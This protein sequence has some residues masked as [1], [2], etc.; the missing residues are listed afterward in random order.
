MTQLPLILDIVFALIAVIFIVV[1]VRR[2]FIKSLIQSA[3]FLLAIVVTYF[4]GPLVSGFIKDK[5][6][7]QPIHDWLTEAGTNVV[8]TLPKFLQPEEGVVG[9]EVLPIANSVSGIISNIIGYIVTFILAL[10]LLT[11]IAWLLTKITDRFT[12]FG[13][14]NRI[15]G[16]VF[17][18]AMGL[19]V[20]FIIAIIVK[21][22]DAEG[23]IYPD[24]TL[25]KLLGNL[26][27]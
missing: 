23:T 5:F 22:L 13:T 27:P 19:I 14:A 11:V 4:V 8:S 24:T 3:K 10:I 16:G 12:F 21:F 1:G 15:L 17:G 20:L 9:Q 26:A 25:I 7:F 2:G 18:A 6:I